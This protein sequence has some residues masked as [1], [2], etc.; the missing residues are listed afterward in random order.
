MSDTP[1]FRFYRKPR[2]SVNQLTSYMSTT[3]AGQRDRIIQ[4]AKFPEK[5]PAAAYT[6]A[7]H[8]IQSFW[9]G[10]RTTAEHFEITLSKLERTARVDAD[11]RDEALRC[12]AAIERFKA[13]HASKRWNGIQVSPGPVDLSL[14]REGV[15]INTRLDTQLFKTTAD[16]TLTG[17]IV[18]FY[19]NTSESRKNIEDRRRQVASIIRWALEENGQMEPLPSLCLSMDIFGDTA[20]RAPDAISTFRQSVDRSCREAAL[21]W[22]TI[23]PPSGYDGPDWR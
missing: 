13:L 8:A 17:G 9:G 18:L 22:D 2:F 6:Q 3:N 21:K 5:I 14:H 11:K 12:I 19:A 15:T 23:E 10:N 16:E 4:K 1:N 20:V 7:R